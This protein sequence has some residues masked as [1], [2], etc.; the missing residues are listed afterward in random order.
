MRSIALVQNESEM[1]HYGYADIRPFLKEM[2]YDLVLY[3]AQNICD[4]TSDLSRQKYDAIIF[5]SNALNDKTISEEVLSSKFKN[6]FITFLEGGKGCLILHQLGL[7]KTK[8]KTKNSTIKF[9]PSSLSSICPVATNKNEKATDGELYPTSITKT[10]IC[11]LYPNDIDISQMKRQCLSYRSLKGL[12]WHYWNQVDNS[13]WDILLHDT[14]TNGSQRPL[15]LASKESAPYRLILSSLTLDWQKQKKILEN[16]LTY[17]VDGKHNI[18]ILKDK[19]NTSVAFEY[20][21]ECLKSQKYPIKIYD[22]N[23]DLTDL[24][25]NIR[26]GVHTVLILD[27][28]IDKKRVG[29]DLYSLVED[30]VRKGKMR[31]MGIDTTDYTLHKFFLA[32]REKYAYRLLHDCEIKI[33]REL[34]KEYI[35]GNNVYIDG[36][37]WSTVE[38]LQIIRQLPEIESRYDLDTLKAVFDSANSHD[39]DGSYD[40]VFGVT[41][42]FLWLRVTYLG[43][44]SEETKKTI[45]WIRDHIKDYDERERVLAYQILNE[46]NSYLFSLD[47]TYKKYLKKGEVKEELKKAFEDKKILF[48]KAIISKINKD[49]IIKDGDTIYLIKEEDK[50]LNIYVNLMTNQG[51]AK[52]RRILSSRKIESL[53]EIDLI[54]YLKAS[55][56]I[57][58]KDDISSYVRRLEKLQND[59]CWIDLA[60]TATATTILLDTL[61]I[62]KNDSSL[63]KTKKTVELIIFKSIIF[64]Q[65]SLHEQR[66]E[67]KK[68]E[69]PWDNKASTSLKC[70]Q[71]WL[72]FENIIDIPIY[73]LIDSLKSYSKIETYKSSDKTAL[74]VLEELKSEKQEMIKE[75]TKLSNKKEQ[76]TKEITKRERT[77]EYNKFLLLFFLILIYITV[78]LNIYFFYDSQDIS[79]G[80]ILKGTFIDNCLIH[81]TFLTLVLASYKFFRKNRLNPFYGEQQ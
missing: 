28:V 50:K 73:E 54:V 33:Q 18:S 29:D 77:T 78:S 32:G 67:R 48:D 7:A 64:I 70:I 9:L 21:I 36:S 56:S 30:L 62:L 12:Y 52:L 61:D 79:I 55:I 22:I 31:L 4:L 42:V 49:W 75:N 26:V 74:S 81:I 34:N 43:V 60:T 14:D 45:I 66:L 38:C 76:L 6:A 57:G 80:N 24:K 71:A 10:H 5:A 53:S 16:I 59:G 63:H 17:I 15:I 23:Q 40:E 47:L 2:K 19:K 65:N 58:Y 51:K 8:N 69:Y 35:D 46:V 25:K 72:K 20:F 3:T 27:P 1:S 41:C 44:N 11:F 13:V 37:F 68:T 39:R